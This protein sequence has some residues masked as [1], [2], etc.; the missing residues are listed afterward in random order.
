MAFRGW[1]APRGYPR[2]HPRV[3]L[4]RFKGLV[5]WKQW[6]VEPWLGTAEAKDRVVG[7]FRASQ[8]LNEWLAAHVS[9]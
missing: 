8:P 3:D 7:L 4:L 2:D 6:P 1:P 5:A 9:S